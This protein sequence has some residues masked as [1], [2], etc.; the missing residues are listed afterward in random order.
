MYATRALF[1]LTKE[2]KDPLYEQLLDKNYKFPSVQSL[3]QVSSK[4]QVLCKKYFYEYW[5]QGG[6]EHTFMK[7]NQKD[8]KG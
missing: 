3:S 2:T 4:T 6:R 8:A 7:A 1:H 5:N